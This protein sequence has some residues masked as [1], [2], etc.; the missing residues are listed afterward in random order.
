MDNKEKYK[1][2][3]ES[4]GVLPSTMGVFYSS[5]DFVLNESYLKT[6]LE[7]S[8]HFTLLR[9]HKSVKEDSLYSKFEIRVGYGEE[10]FDLLITQEKSEG[11]DLKNF[12]LGNYLEFGELES[13]QNQSSYIEVSMY[14]GSDCLSSFHLQL[15]ILY[16]IVPEASLVMDFMPYRLLS[17]KWLKLAAESI[18]A[19]S[20][21]YL[22][23]VHS[24]FNEE[25]KGNVRHW[26]HTHGLHRCGSIELEIIDIG[27]GSEQ[28]YQIL[29]MV[30]KMFIEGNAP[31]A[32]EK[33]A[34]GYDGL[35]INF[36]WTPWEE[37]V[38]RVL[39]TAMG[40]LDDRNEDGDIHREPSGVLWAIEDQHQVSPEIYATALADNPIYFI[41]NKETLRMSA[42]AIER[43]DL[44]EKFFTVKYK[45]KKRSF[46]WKKDEWSFLVKL[47]FLTDDATEETDKEHLWFK[48]LD[49]DGEMLFAELVNEPYWIE[50]LKEGDKKKFP[51]ELL[52]DW[53]IYGPKGSYTSDTIYQLKL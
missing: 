21:E 7:N 53:I 52:T 32:H 44:F 39:P 3:A 15:K 16:A 13:A 11:I 17:G 12:G 35:E 40:G 8:K 14:F 34:V 1:L 41:S 22:Y 38:A 37:A 6:S 31:K 51:L 2:L 19:P 23:V 9:L 20:P 18:I 47:G 48:L 27:N 10:N 24:I 28:M 36:C 5:N 4:G 43:F 42:L 46:F 29:N 45:K 33:F 25:S 49:I 50:S 30:A 26:L